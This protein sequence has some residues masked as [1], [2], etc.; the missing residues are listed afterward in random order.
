MN[1]RGI[2]NDIRWSK[3]IWAVI[4]LAAVCL[5]PAMAAAGEEASKTFHPSTQ[6]STMNDPAEII[7]DEIFPDHLPGDENIR[8][9][10]EKDKVRYRVT[11]DVYHGDKYKFEKP[12]TLCRKKV[13]EVIPEYQTI[14]RERL[15]KHS[16]RYHILIQ[17]ANR[18]F[19]SKI[20]EALEDLDYDL[21]VEKKGIKARRIK[22]PDITEEVIDKITG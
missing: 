16:A 2:N 1:A 3:V 13:F 5:G 10:L 4:V 9:D 12:C 8:P 17:Q 14:K 20:K 11:G 19:R 7:L 21:V 15:N 18:V 6:T 22:I